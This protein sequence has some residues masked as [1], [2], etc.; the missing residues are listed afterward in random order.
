MRLKLTIFVE[1]SFQYEKKLLFY[2][3]DVFDYIV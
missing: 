2:S 1:N 3:V